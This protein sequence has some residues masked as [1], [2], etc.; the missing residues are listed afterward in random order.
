M[1]DGRGS[2]R[3]VILSEPVMGFFAIVALALALAESVLDLRPRVDR[4]LDV[5]QWGIV[6]LFAVE[7]ATGLLHA[8]DRRA[9]A[10]SGWRLLDLVI[11][12][13]PLVTLV[14]PTWT[15]ALATPALRLFRVAAFSAHLGG[16]GS[17]KAPLPRPQ[18]PKDEVHI[19]VATTSEPPREASWTELIERLGKPPADEWFHASGLERS[20]VA[21]I[22]RETGIPETFLAQTLEETAYPRVEVHRRFSAL[23]TW[24][25]TMGDERDAAVERNGVLLLA[26]ENGVLTVAQRTTGLQAEAVRAMHDMALPSGSFAQRTVLGILQLVLRRYESVAGHLERHA[27]ALELRPVRDSRPEFFEYAFL[28][29]RQVSTLRSDLWRLQG[30]L[31]AIADQRLT[32]HGTS[33]TSTDDDDDDERSAREFMCGLVDE[34]EYLYETTSNLREALL[35][36]I[37]LHFNVVSFEMNKFMRLLAAISGIGLIPAVV[38]GLLGMNIFGAPWPVSLAEV[39]FGVTTAMFLALYVFAVKGWLR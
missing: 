10:F 32:F 15:P 19:S 9:F 23:F 11:I 22:A 28:L 12:V 35:E 30:I 33:G 34:A 18:P 6:A 25:P 7:Y 29:Q 27:R 20:H 1:S 21:R 16:L 39:A 26:T 36:L 17:R 14:L 31:E 37:D 3:A 8:S 5:G 13:G 24:L 2:R 38:G 4:L